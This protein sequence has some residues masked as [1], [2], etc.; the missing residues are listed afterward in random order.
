M[1]QTGKIITAV[2][3]TL[4]LAAAITVKWIFFP[5]IKD[6][7]FSMNQR[8]LHQAPS[9]IVV[10][11]PTHFPK[12]FRKGVM[13][14]VIQKSGRPVWQMVG[15]NV[16]FQELVASAYGRSPD[17][18]VLPVD[19]PKT[20]FDFLVTASGDVQHRLQTAIR[21]KLGFIAHAEMRDQEVLAMKVQDASLP[22][23]TLSD[24]SA[25][26]N[27]NFDHG[28][29]HFTHMRLQMIT[30]GLEQVFKKPVVD[31][32]ALTNFYDFSV[33]MDA[34]TQRQLQNETN[35]AVAVKKILAGWGIGL[36]PDS[37]RV[38]ML[39]VRSAI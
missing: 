20:N 17:R 26:P 38:E 24:A 28:K 2:V 29:L 37:D 15:R 21:K 22:G 3:V 11:R 7:Y 27:V 5:S 25:K 18:V 12:S 16:T 13:S 36:V 10:V 39:V 1:T 30:G 6:E 35:A 31:R 32:T 8:S 23:L 4:V 9:G 19:A 34:Q 33:V 14:D